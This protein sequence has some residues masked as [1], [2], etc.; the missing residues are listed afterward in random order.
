MTLTL[1]LEQNEQYLIRVTI[2]GK[3]MVEGGLLKI[4]E[5][6]ADLHLAEFKSNS[7]VR[8][9]MFF[10]GEETDLAEVIAKWK[11]DDT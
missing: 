10:V 7:N 4:G 3:I 8:E 6:R 1:T 5:F 9:G 11:E 2:S